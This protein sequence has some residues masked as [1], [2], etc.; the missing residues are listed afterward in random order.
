[1]KNPLKVLRQTVQVKC[2]YYKNQTHNLASLS[3][4]NISTESISVVTEGKPRWV[5]GKETTCNEGDK[6]LSGSGR[7][8]RVGNGNPLQYSCLEN[9]MD[10]RAWQAIPHGFAKSQTQL[11]D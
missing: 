11:R 5:R 7:S 4:V 10:R 2:I 6:G 8:P 3:T 9:P 1:M